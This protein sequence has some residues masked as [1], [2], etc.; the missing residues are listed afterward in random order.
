MGFFNDKRALFKVY[1]GNFNGFIWS[2]FDNINSDLKNV[3]DELGQ[4]MSGE[5]EKIEFIC[6]DFEILE[7]GTD[8]VRL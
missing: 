1:Y 6:Y 4:K 3:Y 7:V 8:R 5:F 2:T